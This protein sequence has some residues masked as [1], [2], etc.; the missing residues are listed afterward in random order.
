MI[1]VHPDRCGYEGYTCVGIEPLKEPFRH[2]L[3]VCDSEEY[4]DRVDNFEPPGMG[5]LPP[6]E[7]WNWI[8]NYLNI[9]TKVEGFIITTDHLL[10]MGSAINPNCTGSQTPCI[11]PPETSCSNGISYGSDSWVGLWS[12][13]ASVV[14]VFLEGLRSDWLKLLNKWY[15][16]RDGETEGKLLPGILEPMLDTSFSPV[17]L[18]VDISTEIALDGAM[19]TLV[20]LTKWRIK[21]DERLNYLM[22]QIKHISSIRNLLSAMN[23]E[24]ICEEFKIELTKGSPLQWNTT[25][26]KAPTYSINSGSVYIN[27][28]AKV[29]VSGR[30]GITAP[31]YMYVN[32]TLGGAGDDGQYTSVT[33]SMDKT[34]SGD[35]SFGLGGVRLVQ[36]DK[37]YKIPTYYLY[38][39][40]QERCYLS[41]EL[42]RTSKEGVLYRL[43]DGTIPYKVLDTAECDED[44]PATVYVDIPASN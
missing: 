27:G 16:W 32:I 18:D 14:D 2:M 35:A 36:G 28:Q 11:Q 29:N 25:R 24:S 44:E 1:R 31:F 12:L 20:Q 3:M 42:V 30:S 17:G 13:Y 39:I 22:S 23:R 33:V 4:Y 37:Q 7:Q 19:L 34:P 8:D 40:V 43:S 6:E 38:E 41:V 26:P 9:P 21:V 10:N 5:E 15:C